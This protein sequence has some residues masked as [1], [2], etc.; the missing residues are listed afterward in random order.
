MDRISI[1]GCRPRAD[2][3]RACRSA[4][5]ASKC[6]H[7]AGSWLPGAA[8]SAADYEALVAADDILAR[9]R[10]RRQRR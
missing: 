3:R 7:R 2:V 4:P 1:T 6:A 5:A 9:Q 8:N 10:A